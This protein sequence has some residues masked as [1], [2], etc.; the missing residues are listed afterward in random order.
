MRSIRSTTAL[1]LLA[2]AFAA[3]PAAAA[4]PPTTVLAADAAERAIADD[5]GHVV[6]RTTAGSVRI[7]DV[8]GATLADHPLV[9]EPR[10]DDSGIFP[11]VVDAAD[12]LVLLQCG[13]RTDS[14]SWDER[15]RVLDLASG[16]VGDENGRPGLVGGLYS[17][18][19]IDAAGIHFYVDDYK[20][21]RHWAVL[22]TGRSVRGRQRRAL[23]ASRHAL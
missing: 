19:G 16:R 2:T 20:M 23:A 22:E 1:V 4:S 11:A 15:L 5:A 3:H 14:G 9:C 13:E 7:V 21:G 6:Y 17:V 18:L 10:W 8:A 12:G